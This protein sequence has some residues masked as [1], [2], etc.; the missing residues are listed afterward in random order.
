MSAIASR[1]D[2]FTGAQSV[3]QK[4]LLQR[5]EE[6]INGSLPDLDHERHA[7]IFQAWRELG[8]QPSFKTATQAEQKELGEKAA[9]KINRT[10]EVERQSSLVFYRVHGDSKL[11]ICPAKMGKWHDGQALLRA[12]TCSIEESRSTDVA[13]HR[14]T[15]A[16]NPWFVVKKDDVFSSSP[17]SADKKTYYKMSS[18]RACT[19][20]V[21]HFES[22]E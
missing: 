9:A 18:D 19:A 1:P 2:T 4:A 20:Y 11:A 21:L 16:V 15:I 8:E 6:H 22:K 13:A 5:L 12:I 10:F 3:D 17:L 14:V 7:A